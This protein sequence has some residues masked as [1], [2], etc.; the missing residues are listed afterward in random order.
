M[1]GTENIV[2]RKQD[3]THKINLIVCVVV[4]SVSCRHSTRNS[5]LLSDFP[6]SHVCRTRSW[7]CSFSTQQLDN[8]L[9][10]P[11][12]TTHT[13]GGLLVS[14]SFNRAHTYTAST[15]CPW[16]CCIWLPL[17]LCV[18]PPARSFLVALNFLLNPFLSFLSAHLPAGLAQ[19]ST[20]LLHCMVSTR[21][22]C[23]FLHARPGGAGG[24][25]GRVSPSSLCPCPSLFLEY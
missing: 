24:M 11:S 13:V 22:L 5:L 9:M 23:R 15:Q 25:Q 21:V 17:T 10:C 3:N 19:S 14:L 20:L 18:P 2:S 7:G 12:L 16:V 8:C 1:A 4:I 6:L